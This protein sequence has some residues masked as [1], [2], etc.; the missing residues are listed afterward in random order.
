M[1]PPGT[2]GPGII[3]SFEGAGGR[4]LRC[5]VVAAPAPRHHLLYLH[6]IESHGTW[7]L[8]AAWQLMERGCT[9]W[10]LDRRGSG[11]N[12]DPEPGDAASAD[13]LLEDVLRMRR[14]IGVP[15]LSLVG[16]SWG[17]KLATAA[18][19]D[20]PAGLASL[21]LVTPGLKSRVDLGLVTK[22]ALALDLLFG[23]HKRFS[24]PIEPQ[25]FTTTPEH[26]AFIREDPWRLKQV[27][28][29]FLMASRALDRRI[30]DG[31][32]RLE[33]PVLLL[34]AGHDR[35]VD[36]DGVAELLAPVRSLRVRRFEDATHSI[37]FDQL[38][39]MVTEISS[40]LDEVEPMR[41]P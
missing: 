6:G 34:L 25:M 2:P 35:I 38:P 40:F 23:G 12:R 24:V 8:P 33:L 3:E 1:L 9:T 11:L 16:L 13:V 17:G 18:A 7:F 37:Q 31:I 36:N 30:R 41:R 21:V 5:R 10:L 26:L 20:L 22:G 15:Q 39:E 14:R 19:L 29:R 32:A 27:S 4:T 28:G